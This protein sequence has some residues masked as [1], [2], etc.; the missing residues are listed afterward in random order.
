LPE[1]LDL[2]RTQ[3]FGA[4]GYD[5]PAAHNERFDDARVATGGSDI[6][7]GTQ[8][9]QTDCYIGHRVMADLLKCLATGSYWEVE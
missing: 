7:E 8:K 9:P 4:A 5:A 2:V 1:L 3:S 6:I